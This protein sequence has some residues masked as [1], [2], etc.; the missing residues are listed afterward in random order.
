MGITG[1]L[2]EMTKI[3]VPV[4]IRNEDE[5]KQILVECLQS[6]ARD[7]ASQHKCAKAWGIAQPTVNYIVNSKMDRLTI[8]Q[9]LGIVWKSGATISI[10]LN[11]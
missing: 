10:G 9:L 1:A 7:H 5:L 3:S 2:S 8:R 11:F 4:Q 6:R